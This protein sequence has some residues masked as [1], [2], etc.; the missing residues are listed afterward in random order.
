MTRTKRWGL[1]V[2]GLSV[3]GGCYYGD[4]GDS[5]GDW[6]AG[7]RPV[8][9]P[10]D[11]GSGVSTLELRGGY[12]TGTVGPATGLSAPAFELTGMRSGGMDAVQ[13][14]VQDARSDS[15]A[16]VGLSISPSLD[17]AQ[18]AV[19]TTY[20]STT[21]TYGGYDGVTWV[22]GIG[23]QGPRPGAWDYDVPADDVTMQV[24]RGSQPGSRLVRFSV[25]LS[26]RLAEGQFEVGGDATLGT[27]RTGWLEGDLGSVRGFGGETTWLSELRSD[28][29]LTVLME[30]E[31]DAGIVRVQ[32]DTPPEL[33]DLPYGEVVSFG[34]D[35]A[36]G[37]LA[38]VGGAAGDVVLDR[39]SKRVDLLLTDLGPGAGAELSFTADFGDGDVVRGRLGIDL[40]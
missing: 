22:S 9:S 13:L 19:G 20:V 14:T 33:L 2:L 35:A 23:C 17:D 10:Y 18:W 31:S 26:G 38:G 28:D 27:I 12:L 21:D 15:Y 25:H 39:T 6:S 24:E 3:L 5:G 1:C 40:E 29:L 36:L 16:M 7:G 34:P 8:P 32:L 4:Y 11:P 30:R 37:M